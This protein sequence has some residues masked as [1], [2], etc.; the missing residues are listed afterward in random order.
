MCGPAAEKPAL[1]LKG[2]A[3]TGL[4]APGGSETL[5]IRIAPYVLP[6][7]IGGQWIMPETFTVLAGAS[8]EDIRLHADLPA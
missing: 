7:Y 2:F 1:E 8:V 6:S 5:E 3:K 4:L